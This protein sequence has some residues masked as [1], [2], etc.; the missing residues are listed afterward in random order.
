MHFFRFINVDNRYIA[1]LLVNYDANIN[2]INDMGESPLL[3]A[4]KNGNYSVQFDFL[5]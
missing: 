3:L 2:T 5:K 4:V 1:R